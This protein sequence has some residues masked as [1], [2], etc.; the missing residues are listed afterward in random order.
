MPLPDS[1]SQAVYRIV[2]EALTNTIKHARASLIDVRIRYLRQEIEVDVT[3]DGRQRPDAV[4]GPATGS[5]L[6]LIGMRERVAAHDGVLEV[7]ARA[8]GG[9]RVR[10]RLPLDSDARLPAPGDTASVPAA[11]VDAG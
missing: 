11:A 5:G 8:G 7:G 1:L 6:G 4:P 2:Q 10:A 3:D 9:F